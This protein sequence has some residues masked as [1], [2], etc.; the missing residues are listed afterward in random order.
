MLFYSSSVSL[1]TS[2]LAPMASLPVAGHVRAAGRGK[3]LLELQPV[4]EPSTSSSTQTKPP[5]AKDMLRDIQ[6][7]VQL[8]DP[9]RENI[10]LRA[11]QVQISNIQRQLR[12]RTSATGGWS[13]EAT[14]LLNNWLAK[15]RRS[16]AASTLAIMD[17]SVKIPEEAPK[18]SASWSR[19]SSSSSS[20][21]PEPVK[22]QHKRKRARAR[23]PVE[24]LEY[25]VELEAVIG[26][27]QDVEEENAL[28]SHEVD[29][30][31]GILVSRNLGHLV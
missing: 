31:K 30:L 15:P 24:L 1:L 18:S 10:T 8:V 23:S 6:N 27:A 20:T 7:K 29:R 28:L 26:R 4:Q 11:L 22:V 2:L 5:N 3:V 19:S 21:S 13:A 16:T 9:S 25:I 14:V 12:L 17:S